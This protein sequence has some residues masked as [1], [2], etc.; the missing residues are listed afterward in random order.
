MN[1]IAWRVSSIGQLSVLLEVSSPKPGNVSRKRRFSDTDYRHFLA[2]ASFL[3]RG[4]YSAAKRGYDLSNDAIPLE[5]LELGQLIKQC[6]LDVLKGL[7]K[8]NTLLGTIILYIP[9]AT[10]AGALLHEKREFT[11]DGFRKWL[12]FILENTTNEDAI[13]LYEVFHTIDG[14]R[15]DQNKAIRNWTEIHSRYDIDNPNVYENLR[16]DK[17]TLFQLFKISENVDT[18][19]HEWS[20]HY[21][22]VLDDVLPYLKENSTG[23]DDIEEAVVKA[24]IWLLANQIDGLIVKKAGLEMA[25]KVTEKAMEVVGSRFQKKQLDELDILLSYNGNQLN[26]GSTADLISAGLF[27]RLLELEFQ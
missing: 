5:Q 27:C 24:F 9:L 8:R 10:A 4:L 25:R 2:S 13:A 19:S 6:A 1:E 23:L 11:V 15:G 22:T 12:A 20:V 7:N 14:S 21:S 17:I 16:E 3:N 18:I 26:P